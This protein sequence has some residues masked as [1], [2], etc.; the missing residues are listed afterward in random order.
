[1]L[2]RFI[3][4][5][6]LA[7]VGC[8]FYAH[9]EK[10][11]LQVLPIINTDGNTKEI[12]NLIIAAQNGSTSAQN[13][14]GGYYYSGIKVARNYAEAVKWWGMAAKAGHPEAIANLGLCYQMGHGTT[15]NLKMAT[16]LYRK[17]V[18]SG[19]VKLVSERAVRAETSGNL[20]DARF[21]ADIYATGCGSIM[22]D[23]TLA[24]KYYLIGAKAGNTYDM[25]Q[26]GKMLNSINRYAEALPL[27]RQAADKGSP[28]GAYYYGAYLNEGK[29]C[30]VNKRDAAHYLR[31]AA[32]HG[33]AGAQ[34]ALGN[35]YYKGDG[36][37]KNIVEA[38]RLFKAA[39]VQHSAV[40]A[41]NAALCYKNGEGAPRDYGRAVY[42]LSIASK[43]GLQKLV[44]K[45]L[46]ETDINKKG[47][48]NSLFYTYIHGLA[49]CCTE[50]ANFA[51]AEK[52]FRQCQK[53]GLVEGTVM[54]GVC[55]A[56]RRWSKA[57]IKKAIKYLETG[58]NEGSPMALYELGRIYET[59][60][61]V[62]INMR[63]AI[64]LYETAATKHYGP[65]I[66]H[67]GDIYCEGLG[68]VSKDIT[69]GTSYYLRAY[70]EGYMTSTAY[71]NL[72]N[73]YEHGLGGVKRD[74]IKA[75]ALRKVAFTKDPVISML[76]VLTF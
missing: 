52:D 43:S 13:T 14:L 60:N 40:A 61:G 30:T 2:H 76:N 70:L 39:G 6:G 66:C 64:G 75:E 33:V 19:N 22:K 51:A 9:A 44:Q 3:T 55:Y 18:K 47:W 34:L 41:W 10:S 26:A 15:K 62:V 56:N 38:C 17:S 12:K 35:M 8:S 27:F 5:V 1:M 73:A 54:L 63:K 36:I 67:L 21:V 53:A 71:V 11:N 16:E 58:V 65:A 57:N 50:P 29:G 4:I 59:G 25:V 42:W 72:A 46:L 23:A 68:G 31:K 20:F 74:P 48:R 69:K 32:D 37:D 45:Q 49:L 7:F 28:E 24:Y